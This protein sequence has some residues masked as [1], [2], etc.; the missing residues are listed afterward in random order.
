MD[1][2]DSGY[3][4]DWILSGSFFIL[5][6][7]AT[8]MTLSFIIRDLQKSFNKQKELAEEVQQERTSLEN[9]VYQR[10]EALERRLIQIRTSVEINRA[11]S[12]M[13]D[14]Q[15][16][17]QDVTNLVQVR[18]DLYY[19]G[20]FLLD[21]TKTY[22]VLKAGTGEAG[23]KM[24]KAGHKLLVGGSSMI[25]WTIANREARIALDVG[26]EA[27]RF[28]NPNLPQTR[29][30]L[31]LPIITADRPLGA[32]TIQSIYPNAFDEND[33]LVFQSIADSLGI[34]L[35][36]ARL[37]QQTQQDLDEIRSLNRQYLTQAWNEITAVQ[38]NLEYV[39]E[40][41]N[42]GNNSDTNQI[43]IPITLREQTIGKINLE[44]GVTKLK[45]DDL[46][47]V[48][49]IITQTALALESAR[50]LEE[51]RRHAAQE[52]KIN[53]LTAQFSSAINIEE[54]LK[55]AI[56]ELGQLPLVDEVSVHLMPTVDQPV[57]D[58]IDGSGE[59]EEFKA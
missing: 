54:I 38:N 30:E 57:L 44:T 1:T 15:T 28:N 29:S 39:Y 24:L 8:T 31:A 37:F 5:L 9:H 27:V 40:N 45:E 14:P 12:T 55:S 42:Q 2:L 4:Y 32:M 7:T 19:A 26:A 43:Q 22:A 20:V 41:P 18:N 6:A 47:L 10:T 50:L 17:L 25:G 56:Q 34:A 52:E 13:L 53:E 3:W 33:I 51:T 16:L 11:I 35:E 46:A 48:E 59:S 36:T 58:L 23:Q 21:D 49:A